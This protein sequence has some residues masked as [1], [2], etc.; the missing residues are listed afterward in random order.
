MVTSQGLSQQQE[1]KSREILTIETWFNLIEVTSV[2][3]L[4]DLP[5]PNIHIQVTR[6]TWNNPEHNKS[7]GPVSQ[8]GTLKIDYIP[9]N[10]YV[11]PASLT[12]FVYNFETLNIKAASI[13]KIVFNGLRTRL[14]TDTPLT[15]SLEYIDS[16]GNLEILTLSSGDMPKT[17]EI[18]TE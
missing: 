6:L 9:I 18:Q 11:I 1:N 12:S 3:P 5:E 17:T 10:T 16:F 14:G 13:L 4:W 2:Q 8:S 15:V 7:S